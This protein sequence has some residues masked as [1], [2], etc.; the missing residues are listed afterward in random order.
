MRTCRRG[1]NVRMGKKRIMMLLIFLGVVLLPCVALFADDIESY[2]FGGFSIGAQWLDISDL[3]ASL[4]A[5]GFA[6]FN[7]PTLTLGFESYYAIKK[8]F[9]FG[10]EFQHF[11]QEATNSTYVQKLN[12]YWGFFNFGYS[13][14][15]KS[16]EGFHLY[17]MVGLGASRMRLRLT[18]RDV[19]DFSDIVTDP[20][21]ESYLTKWDFIVQ[22]SLGIDYTF[23]FGMEEN[24]GTGGLMFGI[25]TGYQYSVT[26]SGWKMSSLDISGSPGVSMSGIFVRFVV[27]GL[28]NPN[29]EDEQERK[30]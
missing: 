1:R 10:G 13:V 12:G 7:E 27:G 4:S 24:D 3:N 5:N 21:R 25:R 9:V 16:A 20:R 30:Y 17:P 18:Q 23:S 29:P 8:R 19:L 28:G 14:I 15:S 6:T 2:G 22:V 11:W 26:D